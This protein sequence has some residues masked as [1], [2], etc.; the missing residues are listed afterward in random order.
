MKNIGDR[1]KTLRENMNLT[2]QAVSSYLDIPSKELL[3]ME[4][5]NKNITLSI[6]NKLCSLFGCSESYLLCR[7]DEFDHAKFALK[8]TSIE[9]DDLEGIASMNRIYMNMKYLTSKMND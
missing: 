9:T 8:S 4:D 5:G 1:M 7:S 6:L 2:P 3:N